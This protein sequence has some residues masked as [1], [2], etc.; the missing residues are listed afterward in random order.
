MG[1][2]KYDLW[3]NLCTL[4]YTIIPCNLPI[5]LQQTIIH[6][7]KVIINVLC[8]EY[9]CSW[10]VLIYQRRGKEMK[11]E[12]KKEKKGKSNM[13][14]ELNYCRD[15]P[16]SN[17]FGQIFFFHWLLLFQQCWYLQGDW[18]CWKIWSWMI[19][20]T[21]QLKYLTRHLHKTNA[22]ISTDHLAV[23]RFRHMIFAES[24]EHCV[25]T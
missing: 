14:Y 3:A 19:A 4:M 17:Y 21:Q 8:S 13:S 24:D 9:L 12:R 18:G 22:S 25:I 7:C 20:K 6:S 5:T 23:I 15:K 10:K 16:K 11:T 2:F 1:D